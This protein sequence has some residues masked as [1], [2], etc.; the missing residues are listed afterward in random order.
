MATAFLGI[1]S[2]LGDRR[3]NCVRAVSLLRA[4]PAIRVAAVSPWKE[5]VA[6]TVDPDDV[7]PN[8]VNGVAQV[9]TTLVPEML[10]AA[11]YEVEAKL[12]RDREGR[13]RWA[14]RTIDMD[15]LLYDDLVLASPALT[16]PHPE[17]AK[18]MF[19]LEP[20][21]MLAPGL[22]HPVER[23]TMEELRHAILSR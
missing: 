7:Q 2:N 1:G 15:I 14:P 23:K 6:L 20:L 17:L 9:A 11:C 8:Y 3:G 16:I 5:Y 10:L 22:V 12:G 18:R 4:H 13:R 19:V 21:A